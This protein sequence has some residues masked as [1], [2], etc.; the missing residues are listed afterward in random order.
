MN[1]RLLP[2]LPAALAALGAASL[3]A[4]D[5]ATAEKTLPVFQD[6]QAQEVPAFKDRNNWIKEFLWVEAPFDSDGDGKPDRLHVDVWRPKQTD[7]EG[8]KVPVVYET[9]P[10]FA[11]TG[12]QTPYWDT[13]HEVG[14]EPP[15]R[16]PAPQIAERSKAGMIAQSEVMTWLPRGFAVVHSES[17][18]TGF[19][20]GCPT[21]GGANEALA[22]KAVIDWLCGRLKAYD[23]R[24]GGKEVVASW[25]SGKVGMIGTSYNGTL[26]LAA[27]TTGVEGLEA[28][29]PIAPN[30]SSYHYYRSH[31]LVRHPGGYMGEDIDVLYDFINSGRTERR[32]WCNEHVRD[33]ELL[34]GFGRRTGDWNDFWAGRDYAL[35]LDKFRCAMLMSHGWND[36]NV[37]PEHSVRIYS[38]VKQKGLPCI[39]FFHQAGHGGPPPLELVNKWFTRF[40]YGIDN[41]VERGPRSWIVREGDRNSNPTSYPD[42]PHPEAALVALHGSGDGLKVGTLGTAA[43]KGTLKIVDNVDKKGAQLAMAAESPHRLLFATP[44]LTAPLHLS[45]TARITVKLASSKPAANLSVWLVPLPLPERGRPYD[46]IVTRGWADPQNHQSLSKG[47]PLVPGKF[48]TVTFDLQPDDQVIPAGKQLGLMVFSSDWDFTL[49]PPAGTELTIDLAGT[50]LELPVVGGAKAFAAATAGK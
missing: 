4:Q 46:S 44:P 22:P 31:G 11:G 24:E 20:D 9:S 47:E 40:L 21:V 7:T 36:W 16:K 15:K 14:A 45:G 30:T 1:Q 5:T 48:V 33:G 49:R 28:I 19:S 43:G 6:G 3:R 27:A 32:A 50:V 12:D 39:A 42:Y 25:C 18:G 8:L 23:A 2:L 38:A 10:Y 37:M 29:V 17:P 26:P 41:G 13:N 35:Q 34:Q